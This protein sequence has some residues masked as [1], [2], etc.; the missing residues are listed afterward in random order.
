M[1]LWGRLA[2]FFSPLPLFFFFLYSG[3]SKLKPFLLFWLK[4]GSLT[5]VFFPVVQVMNFYPKCTGPKTH[6]VSCVLLTLLIKK[7]VTMTQ[8]LGIFS[9]YSDIPRSIISKTSEAYAAV[10]GQKKISKLPWPF[11]PKCFLFVCLHKAHLSQNSFCFIIFRT[12]NWKRHW[13]A[14]HPMS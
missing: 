8:L 9:L 6:Y 12:S 14:C 5:N 7:S 3:F 2:I 13:L 11:E 1:W 4:V 10:M